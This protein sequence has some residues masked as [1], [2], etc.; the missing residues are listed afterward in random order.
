MT[1]TTRPVS[2]DPYHMPPDLMDLLIE[3]IP[4]L[5]RSKPGV[6]A[7]FRGCGIPDR[8]TADLRAQ[9]ET[10]RDSISKYQITRIILTRINEQGDPA[11]TQRRE[12][13]RRVTGFEDFSAC[14]PE[15][16]LKA[17]GLVAAI[18]DV[19][20]LKDSLTRILQAQD[21]V[22]REH[23]REQEAQAAAKRR[24]RGEREALRRRFTALAAMT[25]PR[26]RGLAFESALNDLFKLDGLCIREAFTLASSDG[27]VGEQFDGLVTMGSHPVLVEAKWH[28]DQLGVN[29]VCRHLV[30]VYG[31][32][33]GVHGLIISASGFAVPAIDE[34]TRALASRVIM[35]AELPE[36][37]MLLENPA[38]S[39][40]AW[41]QAKY[42]AARVDWRVLFRPG[43]ETLAS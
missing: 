4:M 15:D 20:N 35:L 14:W 25:V 30:R 42:L 9:V 38:A 22:L 41:L 16:R 43:T 5:C 7:F 37:F 32:P 11:L 23:Q 24:K 3:A 1:K 17:Q 29:D 12:V 33:P 10:D 8:L 34:C 28:A 31:R 6:L 18:R 21:G 27:K 36:L 39:I 40:S 13:V 2:D 26:Q 19:V